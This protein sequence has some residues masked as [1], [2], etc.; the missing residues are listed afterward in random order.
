MW[1]EAIGGI[2]K[3]KVYTFGLNAHSSSVLTRTPTSCFTSQPDGPLGSTSSAYSTA[4]EAM[5]MTQEH[6]VMALMNL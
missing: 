5:E 1:E 2:S 4:P 6:I 3:N